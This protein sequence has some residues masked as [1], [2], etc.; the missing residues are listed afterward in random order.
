MKKIVICGA[1]GL[2]GSLL[3]RK[4]KERGDALIVIGRNVERLRDEVPD[5]SGHLTWEQFRNTEHHELD[6]IVN[7]AGAGVMDRRW[8]EAYT[9]IMTQSRVESTQT[10]AEI[11]ALDPGGSFDQRVICP[12]LRSPC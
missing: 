3:T 8:T 4:L 2:V 5:A 1:S 10:C 12:C 9:A 6:C 7:L 11:C